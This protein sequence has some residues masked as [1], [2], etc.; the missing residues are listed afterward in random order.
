MTNGIIRNNFFY[1]RVVCLFGV[2]EGTYL[3]NLLSKN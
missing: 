1:E 3:G 2:Q